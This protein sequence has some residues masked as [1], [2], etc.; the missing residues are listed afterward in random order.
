MLSE[1]ETTSRKAALLGHDIEAVKRDASSLDSSG[2][3]VYR[4]EPQL[5]PCCA[6][7]FRRWIPTGASFREQMFCERAREFINPNGFT[8]KL[9]ADDRWPPAQYLR[10][11]VLPQIIQRR[12]IQAAQDALVQAGER[13]TITEADGLALAEELFAE[14][15][16]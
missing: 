3:R 14:A 7:D 5:P 11:R 4:R 8:C 2:I 16:A 13:R 10:A 6:G 9:C 1:T 15:R 12:G